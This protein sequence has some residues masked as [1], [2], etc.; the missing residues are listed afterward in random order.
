M[1]ASVTA[2]ATKPAAES[3][4]LADAGVRRSEWVILVFLVYAASIGRALPIAPSLQ[5]RTVVVNLAILIVYGLLIRADAVRPRMIT[6]VIRDWLPLAVIILAYR[7]VG[8]FALPY[9]GHRLEMR[10]VAWDRAFLR[11]GAKAAIESL[12]PVL[13][14]ILEIAYALVYA[15]GPFCLAVL[16][17]SGRRKDADRF[18][19][20]FATAVL[21]TYA[22]LPLWPSEPPRTVFPG[23]DAPAYLTVFR[24]FNWWTLA[25]CGIHT[26]VFP[27]AHVAGAFAAAF[28]MRRAA[29]AQRRVH[30]LLFTVA[31]LIA[32]ATVYGRYHYL[33]DAVAGLAMATLAVAFSHLLDARR[34]GTIAPHRIL[35]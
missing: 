35:R 18:L 1:Q 28:G 27:S 5:T 24:R 19:F 6:S 31:A 8:W 17:S 12:G 7:E 10:W 11:G 32:L 16:Y 23:E 22:Q 30:A 20:V 29:A 9:P 34:D 14:S 13:P 21:L 2:L 26:G 15:L 4:I 33:V 3:R 25:G